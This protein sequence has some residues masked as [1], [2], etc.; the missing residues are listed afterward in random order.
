MVVDEDIELVKRCLAGDN[1]AFA[2]IVDK[3]E[4][5]VYNV[6]IRMCTSQEDAEDITQSVF[7]KAFEG[8]DTFKPRYK[9]FSWIYRIAV[10][11]S[12][13]VVNQQRRFE[14]LEIDQMSDDRTPDQSYEEIELREQ[15]QD[16][17]M[18]LGV[19]YRV[20]LVLNHFHDLSYS[21]IG[22][23]LEIPEKTV[24]SRLFTARCLLKDKLMRK[25]IG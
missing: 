17:L 21:E 18:K 13:N 4:K 2:A 20:V 12:L 11:E 14:K 9:F 22:Y 25:H 19:E 5:I 23:I 8:L 16:C 10:N 3:Y 7:T 1:T 6:A 15:V 24:K